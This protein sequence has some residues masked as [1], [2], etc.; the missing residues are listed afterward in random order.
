MQR[1]HKNKGASIPHLLIV[2]LLHLYT[3][4][5]SRWPCKPNHLVSQA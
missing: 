4:N 5:L 1:K 3:Y 2:F